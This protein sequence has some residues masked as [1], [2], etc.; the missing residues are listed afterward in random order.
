MHP[1]SRNAIW[2]KPGSY[3]RNYSAYQ[4]R[5]RLTMIKPERHPRLLLRNQ[6]P[7]D[8]DFEFCPLL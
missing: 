5:K 4:G 6:S 7:T 2:E 8:E 3:C 1:R